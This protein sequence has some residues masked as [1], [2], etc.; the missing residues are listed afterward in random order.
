MNKSGPPLKLAIRLKAV[1]LRG[2]TSIKMGNRSI[3]PPLA[4]SVF[5]LACSG[6]ISAPRGKSAMTNTRLAAAKSL[7]AWVSRIS[8][9]KAWQGSLQSDPMKATKSGRWI[10]NAIC[11]ASLPLEC[12][13]AAPE[14]PDCPHPASIT[15]PKQRVSCATLRGKVMEKRLL[16]RVAHAASRP[17]YTATPVGLNRH[18]GQQ[19]GP[20]RR[21]GACA[22][23]HR[24]EWR[25]HTRLAWVSS[26]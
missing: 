16:C 25:L 21:D 26:S 22:E 11:L 19:P 18:P 13:S 14:P 23:R 8:F 2:S 12:Q 20:G 15:A 7:K 9:R 1:P 10:C 17:K 4:I 3:W 24:P 5:C 6:E